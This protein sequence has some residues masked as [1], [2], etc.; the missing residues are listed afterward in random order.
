MSHDR[1]WEFEV[2]AAV[3]AG[4]ASGESDTPETDTRLGVDPAYF[5]ESP[6]GNGMLLLVRPPAPSASIAA[7]SGAARRIGNTGCLGAAVGACFC[8]ALF[9]PGI[10]ILSCQAVRVPQVALAY[11]PL[12][13]LL[14]LL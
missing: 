2:N 14:Y 1:I 8:A 9:A 6:A 4:G 12:T 13:F 10:F 11:M 5:S 3:R 7:G